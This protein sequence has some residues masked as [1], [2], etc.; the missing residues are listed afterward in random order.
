M[1]KAVLT[2]IAFTFA[3]VIT[4]SADAQTTP[5][6]YEAQ[7]LASP[8][9]ASNPARV[10]A[11]TTASPPSTVTQTAPPPEEPHPAGPT[12]TPEGAVGGTDSK[13][14]ATAFDIVVRAPRNVR[15][16]L[17]KHMELKRYQ[18]VSD[19]EDAELARL[20]ELAER[21]VRNLVGTL[22]YFSPEIR[23]TRE[24]EPGQRPT[25]A[26]AV[27]PGLVTQVKNTDIT[28]SG[29]IA[30]TQEADAIDQRERIERDWRLPP[31]QPFTQ[32]TWDAAKTQ[33][34]RDL[35]ARR[36]PTGRVADSLSDIDPAT[37]SAY[38]GLKL[39]SG[40]TYRLGGLTISGVDRYNAVL[41][42]RLARLSE[43]AVYDQK[44]LLAAQQRLASSGYYESANVFINPQEA[45]DPNAVPVQ[46]QVRETKLKKVILGVGV[47]TD[48]GP[49]ASVEYTS[50]K[51]VGTDWRAV[52]SLE[53]QRKSPSL[54][55][56][57][58]SLP[59]EDL[60]RWAGLARA[61]RIDD[62]GLI[63]TSER[64]RFGRNQLGDHI[65]RNIYLQYDRSK[66]AGM[67]NGITAAEAGDGSAISGNWI[68]TGR[69][70]DSLPFPNKGFG[71]SVQLG[72]GYTLTGDRQPYFRTVGRWLGVQPLAVGR[73]ALRAEAGAVVA[74]DSARLPSSELF[75]TGGDAT[76]RGYGYRD[77]G[78]R[79]PNGAIGPGRYLA[80]GSV[81]YQ[82]PLRLKGLPTDF[83]N[84]FFIDAGAVADKPGD[85][86]PSVGIGTGVRWKSPI[87]PLQIDIA[88]GVKAKQI[89][90]HTSVGFVF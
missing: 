59:D 23:I 35:V 43:G 34:L 49:R 36:Y 58:T 2:A 83:E 29:E 26:V 62:G 17:E 63:T 75:R 27:D 42:P 90:L 24:G 77:I 56:E 15:E 40:P 88:Y 47:S 32:E 87:G 30:Q 80:V 69:Y 55:T 41:V 76:V 18:A 74:R 31:G 25:I 22:G 8:P 71:L 33:A 57:W 10:A 11:A 54:Q 73:F 61:E 85:L 72:G 16:L 20:L 52:T 7:A 48:S 28:F 82:R 78:I 44:E 38:L 5:P 64:L 81:E 79:L 84:T 53:I 6:A 89:R 3:Q 65:D 46:V 21:N 19:L 9:D 13:T 70:F 66:V 67:L 12:P 14:E 50:Q 37:D 51:A 68:W 86:K 60:W 4:V 1:G 39:D 45:A